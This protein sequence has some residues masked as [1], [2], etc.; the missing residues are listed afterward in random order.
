MTDCGCDIMKQVLKKCVLRRRKG[1]WRGDPIFPFLS[2]SLLTKNVKN[3]CTKG[4]T[5]FN[6]SKLSVCY[7][8]GNSLVPGIQNLRY[9]LRFQ[10]AS[11]Q[12]SLKD[13]CR[14]Q[15][16]LIQHNRWKE[17]RL[18]HTRGRC[19]YLLQVQETISVVQAAEPEACGN[20]N[21]QQHYP[22]HCVL[23]TYFNLIF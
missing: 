8:P 2:L 9:G 11:R 4:E 6:K 3:Y 13:R 12:S 1:T 21:E 15:R 20:N 19:L 22:H 5:E 10:I 17:C 18:Q 14:K 23:Q 16:N 7:G